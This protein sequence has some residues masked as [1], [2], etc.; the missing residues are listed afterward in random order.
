M[1]IDV[2]PTEQGSDVVV[3]VITTAGTV[4]TI[5]CDRT[6]SVITDCGTWVQRDTPTPGDG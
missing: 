1:S 2:G 3:D 4:H 6:G 5:T